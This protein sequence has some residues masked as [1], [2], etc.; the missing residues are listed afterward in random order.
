MELRGTL[1]SWNDQ[2]GFGFIRPERGGEDV[3]AH[4][5]AVHGERRPLVGD[6]VLYVVGRDDRGRVRAEHVRLDAPPT[7]DQPAIRQR[8]A[9]SRPAERHS[10][11]PTRRL[12]ASVQNLPGKL[13]VF[14]LLCALPLL[15]SLFRLGSVLPL[16]VYATA[17]LLTFFLYWRDKHSALKDRWR[18]PESTL[19]VFELA[20]GWPGALLAQQLFRH[21]TRKLGYQLL[22]WLIVVLHQAFWIDLLFIGGA[23]TRERWDWLLRLF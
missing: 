1:K 4:I 10:A 22:F 20:G 11:R 2:K 7:L 12:F 8:P 14:A 19:H 16:V 3:F 5:S 6:R 18:T 21:K 17:S 23:V 13:L 15:G 9:G